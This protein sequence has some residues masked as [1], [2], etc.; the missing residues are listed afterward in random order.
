MLRTT[1]F[2]IA[3]AAPATLAL[4][5]TDDELRQQI[6]GSWGADAECAAWSV[7]FAAD[8]L[9]VLDR[10]GTDRDQMGKWTISAGVLSLAKDAGNPEPDAAIAFADDTV[11]LSGTDRGTPF[12][13]QFTRCRN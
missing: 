12:R 9:Y 3:L 10:P 1:V 8:G 2:S 7:N 13:Q 6:A 4:A 5:A 11:V